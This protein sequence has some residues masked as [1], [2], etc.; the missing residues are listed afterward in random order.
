VPPRWRPVA[1]LPRGRAH[2]ARTA[3]P[4]QTAPLFLGV[5][6]KRARI[7]PE[8]R[9]LTQE[10]WSG[11]P[12]GRPPGCAATGRRPGT[13]ATP[14]RGARRPR[15]PLAPHRGSARPCSEGGVGLRV[16]RVGGP[17]HT[18]RRRRITD[19]TGRLP[20]RMI[21]QGVQGDA[22]VRDRCGPWRCRWRSDPHHDR[23]GG[24]AENTGFRCSY[25]WQA[26]TTAVA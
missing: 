8:S 12:K 20:R 21:V 13:T 24:E 19:I 14:A 7:L 3:H 11:D 6:R 17:G 10:I 25:I 23:T 2:S 18:G 9:F 16:T 1:P 22:T 4:A 5:S 15:T 26:R